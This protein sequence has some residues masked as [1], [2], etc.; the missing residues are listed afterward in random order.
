MILRGLT[1]GD[2]K[3]T[4]R[5]FSATFSSRGRCLK[6]EGEVDRGIY[7]S[8]SISGAVSRVTLAAW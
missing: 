8:S 1:P 3:V 6:R 7:E 2:G 5:G 4:I